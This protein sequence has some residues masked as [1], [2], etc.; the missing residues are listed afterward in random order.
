MQP[1]DVFLDAAGRDPTELNVILCSFVRSFWRSG[2]PYGRASETVNAVA[3][4]KPSLKRLLQSVWDLLRQWEDA[5]P[6]E[7]NVACPRS[8]LG[9]FAALAMLRGWARVGVLLVTMF[10]AILR[11]SEILL[12]RRRHLVLPRDSTTTSTSPC[13]SSPSQRPD[14]G[15]RRLRDSRRRFSRRTSSPRLISSTVMTHQIHRYG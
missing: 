12:A 2:A 7:H 6:G 13:S 1:L 3:A 8:V 11:P 14:G 10:S 9:A 5:E 15:L 4:A